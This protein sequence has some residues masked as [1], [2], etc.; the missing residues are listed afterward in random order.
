[1]GK[2]T[3]LIQLGGQWVGVILCLGLVLILGGCQLPRRPAVDRLFLPLT[4]SEVTSA[5]WPMLTAEPSPVAGLTYDPQVDRYV[6]LSVQGQIDTLDLTSPETAASPE[7]HGLHPPGV[8]LQWA[9]AEA[10][11]PEAIAVQGLVWENAHQIW[12]MGEDSP[13]TQLLVGR[14]QMPAG[15]QETALRLPPTYG[16]LDDAKD[17]RPLPPFGGITLSPDRERLFALLSR[18]L[19]QDE[20]PT[21]PDAV[22]I[23]RLLHYYLVTPEPTLVAEHGYPLD[24]ELV[25]TGQAQVVGLLAVDAAGRFLTLEV[26]GTLDHPQAKLFQVTT[27]GATDTLAIKSLAQPVSGVRL[28]RKRLVADLSH[29]APSVGL[30]HTLSWG[31][32]LTDGSQRILVLSRNSDTNVETLLQFRL[33]RE[34]TLAPT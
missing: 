1:M 4:L 28:L 21:Q 9:G 30:P 33:S 15:R 6:S 3:G 8:T 16:V 2:P 23:C 10:N 20:P 19:P 7:A 5:A 17:A 29:T 31:A 13:G 18:P 24:P 25:A 27:A 34:G 14:F 22:S 26:G 11:D 12:V 32:D